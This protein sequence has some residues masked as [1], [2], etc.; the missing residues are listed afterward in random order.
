MALIKNGAA[1]TALYCFENAGNMLFPNHEME[2]GSLFSDKTH[3][4][5]G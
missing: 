1:F 5:V 4:L 3:I 2:C